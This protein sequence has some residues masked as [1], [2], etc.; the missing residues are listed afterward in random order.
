MQGQAL[1]ILESDP[2][3]DL[4]ENINISRFYRPYAREKVGWSRIS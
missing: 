3:L 1:E 4:A 2:N